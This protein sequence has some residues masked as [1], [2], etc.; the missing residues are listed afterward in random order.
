M[1]IAE[2]PNPT[3]S[4][5]LKLVELTTIKDNDGNAINDIPIDVQTSFTV[6][7]YNTCWNLLKCQHYLQNWS[8]KPTKEQRL[9]LKQEQEAKGEEGKTAVVYGICPNVKADMDA[10]VGKPVPKVVLAA[11]YEE[12]SFNVL[13][14]IEDSEGNL[15]K[16]PT[17][18]SHLWEQYKMANLVG[19][20]FILN[21]FDWLAIFDT[22][23]TSVME[24]HKHLF[25]EPAEEK[26]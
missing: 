21:G 14:A 24:Q 15:W 23:V 12:W 10:L 6:S 16:S 4:Q 22:A 1:P 3:S 9:K 26:K 13:Q 11:L 20:T 19:D 5:M 2:T 17:L 25:D 18:Q 8:V 7:I